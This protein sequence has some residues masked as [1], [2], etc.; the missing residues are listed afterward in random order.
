MNDHRLYTSYDIPF[1]QAS[2]L[3][4]I[5]TTKP[6]SSFSHHCRSFFW[7]SCK[8]DT[9][10]STQFRDTK[11]L[12]FKPAHLGPLQYNG[13]NH[14]LRCLHPT[15]E[16]WFKSWGLHFQSSSQKGSKNV[17][18]V[19]VPATHGK[20]RRSPSSWIQLN[21]FCCGHLE[22]KLVQRRGIF[23]SIYLSLCLSNEI[24]N[25]FLNQPSLTLNICKIIFYMDS[26]CPPATIR[27]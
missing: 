13:L 9:C 27:L 17:P 8:E 19:S 6:Q 2:K 3:T 22:N 26:F 24:I 16:C 18:S 5:K 7:Q 10:G 25:K 12:F 20:P 23:L 4:M 11:L 15:W 1:T 14:S 21:P